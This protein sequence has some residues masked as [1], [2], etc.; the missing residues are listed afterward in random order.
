MTTQKTFKRGVRTRMA[1]T[2]ESYATART[3]LVRKADGRP[4]APNARATKPPD[5]EAISVASAPL[6]PADS[7]E[8]PMSDEAVRKGTGRSWD[9]WFAALD[10]LGATQLPRREIVLWLVSEHAVGGWWAQSVTGGYERARGLRAKHQMA[11]GYSVAASR[12]IGV[13]ADE[14]LAAFTDQQIRE[15]WLPDVVLRQRPT[16][17]SH[18]ARFDWPEPSSVV[19][20]FVTPAGER[21]SRVTVQHDRLPDAATADQFKRF[22]RE[23]VAVLRSLLDDPA[24][25]T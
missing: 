5:V 19:V 14:L 15:R 7:F 11:A 8:L 20:V 3:Q 13:A 9:E 12:T 4:G 17:A 10:H 24:E 16:R 18:T 1:K 22:W 25:R 2:G 23:R 6:L 21:K